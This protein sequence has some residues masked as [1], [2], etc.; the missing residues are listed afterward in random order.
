MY[1]R[2]DKVFGNARAVRKIV[3]QT[4]HKQNIRMAMMPTEER[5]ADVMKHLIKNDLE[6]IFQQKTPQ[7]GGK[8]GF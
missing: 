2:R 1:K 8:I 7:S 6:E 4:I 5:S 3:E